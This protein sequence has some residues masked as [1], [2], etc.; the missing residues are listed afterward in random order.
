M[1]KNM[2]KKDEHIANMSFLKR[3]LTTVTNP[4]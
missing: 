4:A 3:V 2:E 1:L